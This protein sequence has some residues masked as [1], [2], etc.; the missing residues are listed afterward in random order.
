MMIEILHINEPNIK[1]SKI[2]SSDE[3]AD[4]CKRQRSFKNDVTKQIKRN[5]M[6]D[7]I[8]YSASQVIIGAMIFGSII[9]ALIL[10]G[11]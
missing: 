9:A 4:L 7:S 10:G 3:R 6:I 8:C 2:V 5:N 1:A 11:I